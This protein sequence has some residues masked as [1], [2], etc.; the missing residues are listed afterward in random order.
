MTQ[1]ELDQRALTRQHDGTGSPWNKLQTVPL[2][3]AARKRRPFKG[4]ADSKLRV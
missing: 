3:F 4:T 2:P 1:P